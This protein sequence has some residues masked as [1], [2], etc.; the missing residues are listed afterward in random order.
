MLITSLALAALI[1][2]APAPPIPELPPVCV[3]QGKV[4]WFEGSLEEALAR[5]VIEERAIF[6][7][8]W[9]DP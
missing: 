6:L 1:L 5:A 7:H 4:D 8:V 2:V 3:S 9:A